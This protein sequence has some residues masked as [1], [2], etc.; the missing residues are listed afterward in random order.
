MSYTTEIILMT[1]FLVSIEKLIIVG[2]LCKIQIDLK[3]M[4]QFWFSFQKS[5]KSFNHFLSCSS[6]FQRYFI[7]PNYR[8]NDIDSMPFRT[9]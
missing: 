3:D 5:S 2:I 9:Q 7:Y 4:V 6:T 8:Y 1:G